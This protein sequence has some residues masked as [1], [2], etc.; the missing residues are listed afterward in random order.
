MGSQSSGRHPYY[1]G[2]LKQVG[3][4]FPIHSGW[5]QLAKR[6]CH[7]RGISFNE[8]VRLL[9]IKEVRHI[10]YT[11]MWPCKCTSSTGKI[12]YHFKGK[13][14]CNDC[15]QYQLEVYEKMGQRREPE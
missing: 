4:K 9:I 13:Q 15:G 1:G 8:F 7:Y 2:A 14:Y 3:L 5:F 11:K 12:L 10:Q 6:I